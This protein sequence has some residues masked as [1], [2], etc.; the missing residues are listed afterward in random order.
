MNI[1]IN[2]G[3]TTDTKLVAKKGKADTSI[4]FIYIYVY[5]YQHGLKQFEP[6]IST[7]ITIPVKEWK[8]GKMVCEFL[9]P[10]NS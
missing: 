1:S 4:Y 6:S 10:G 5:I 3:I 9:H 8:K 7:G 2:N